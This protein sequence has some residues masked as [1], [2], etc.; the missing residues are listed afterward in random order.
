[1][2]GPK[3]RSGS[4]SSAVSTASGWPNRE[5]PHDR[6]VHL[7]EGR[8]QRGAAP[9]S[10]GRRCSAAWR[11]R[12]PCAG[13]GPSRSHSLKSQMPQVLRPSCS[14]KCRRPVSARDDGRLAAVGPAAD[15]GQRADA[16]G[17]GSARRRAGAPTP[18]SSVT[19]R[20]ARRISAWASVRQW[21]PPWLGV[22]ATTALPASSLHQLGVDLHAHRV[23]PAGDVADR[24]GQR[25]ALAVAI[26]QL[27]LDLADVPA[28]A[29][30]RPVDVGAGQPPGLAD[31][32]D[33]QQR[34]QVAMVGAG[35]RPPP[36]TRALR[37]SRS[38][39]APGLVL[40]AGVRDRRRPPAS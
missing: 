38:T 12:S 6:Q 7:E 1:M 29:V 15:E 28:H 27:P 34:Q 22:L 20:P 39:C 3:S 5:R 32:P 9:R 2:T 17:C 23:V 13:A 37:S 31:L 10:G 8:E 24:A 35:R 14:S 18:D 25:G 30:E 19:G 36:V 26:G 33:Q 40:A 4:G 16:L 11:T 21:K